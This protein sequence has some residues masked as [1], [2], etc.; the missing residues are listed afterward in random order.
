MVVPLYTDSKVDALQMLGEQ[1]G[2]ESQKQALKVHDALVF[3]NPKNV[4]RIV[5][6]QAKP[7]PALAPAFGAAGDTV[8]QV[9]LL[10]H[11]LRPEMLQPLLAN[12]LKGARPGVEYGAAREHSVGRGRCGAETECQN[13]SRCSGPG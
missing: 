3:G 11:A 8:A 12:L 4:A 2:F 10:P 7:L 6:L 13:P 9:V 5:K 1:L